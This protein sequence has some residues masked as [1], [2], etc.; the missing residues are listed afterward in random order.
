MAV[1]GHTFTQQDMGNTFEPL[2]EGVYE[3]V[4]ENIEKQDWSAKS[5]PHQGVP[6]LYLKVTYKV[7]ND[8][9]PQLQYAGRRI[10]GN[11]LQTFDMNTKICTQCDG[12]VDYNKL[13]RLLATQKNK[14]DYKTDFPEGI[15]QFI[16]YMVGKTLKVGVGIKTDMYNGEERTQNV[17]KYWQESTLGK[18]VDPSTR[19]Q[20]T[21]YTNTPT[22]GNVNV[23]ESV[24]ITDLDE[25]LP[26]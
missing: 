6:N 20:Q 14:D 23:S 19:P 15:D 1:V 3:C 16:M 21:T 9:N 22:A 17:V 4:I 8:Q 18:Y 5:G 24:D 7:R 2:P 12:W 10:F 13:G 11:I 25:S 26:F